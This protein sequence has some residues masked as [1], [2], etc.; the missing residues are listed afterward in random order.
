MW[1]WKWPSARDC[2][3]TGGY[4]EKD[5]AG[6]RHRRK[7][8]SLSPTRSQVSRGRAP[9]VLIQ[10]SNPVSNLFVVPRDSGNHF[11]PGPC[12]LSSVRASVLHD[13]EMYPPMLPTMLLKHFSRFALTWILLLAHVL[14]CEYILGS[15]NPAYLELK[16]K[17]SFEKWCALKSRSSEMTGLSWIFRWWVYSLC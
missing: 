11:H 8:E 15:Q 3:S 6:H 13:Q 1:P 10:E 9:C 12:N 4:Q 7:A 16:E 5:D 17:R 2:T 14:G